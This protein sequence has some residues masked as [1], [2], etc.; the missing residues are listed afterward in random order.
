MLSLSPPPPLSPLIS[1][2]FPPSHRAPLFGHRLPRGAQGCAAA[3]GCAG[4]APASG[5]RAGTRRCARAAF[6]SFFPIQRGP[7]GAG[8]MLGGKRGTARLCAAAAGHG[9]A[10]PG[11]PPRVFLRGLCCHP[12]LRGDPSPARG[13]PCPIRAS[14]RG[15]AGTAERRGDGARG[16][17]RW[18]FLHGSQGRDRIPEQRGHCVGHLQRLCGAE[19]LRRYFQSLNCDIFL[20]FPPAGRVVAFRRP[21]AEGSAL[22]FFFPLAAAAAATSAGSRSRALEQTHRCRSDICL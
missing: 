20:S 16:H 17:T 2:F 5:S 1:F 6:L 11:P 15:A 9:K 12:Q 19:E 13:F 4:W 22:C 21:P 10:A 18:C 14:H 3:Q 8:G 7:G